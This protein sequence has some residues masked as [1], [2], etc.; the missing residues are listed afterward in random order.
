[1]IKRI[2]IFIIG[3]IIFSSCEN[4]L[5]VTEINR[6]KR[7]TFMQRIYTDTT[8]T[9][10]YDVDVDSVKRGSSFC[11]KLFYFDTMKKGD[12]VYFYLFNKSNDTIV[13]YGAFAKIEYFADSLLTAPTR[14][15]NSN[16]TLFGSCFVS[17]YGVTIWEGRDSVYITK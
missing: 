7:L 6:T 9:K 13:K 17:R 8:Y 14:F 3:I 16:L 12:F 1:M 4:S 10:Y 5:N 2:I 15:N 11:F